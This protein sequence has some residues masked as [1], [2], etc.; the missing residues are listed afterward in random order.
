MPPLHA[1]RGVRRMQ[2]LQFD[3]DERIQTAATEALCNMLYCEPVYS[4]YTD[5]ELRKQDTIKLW[6]LLAGAE[7]IPLAR[8]ASGGLALLTEDGG[9]VDELL[10]LKS[11]GEVLGELAASNSDELRHRGLHTLR[12]VINSSA[13][14]AEKL[15]DSMPLVELLVAVRETSSNP[16]LK[17]IARECLD[18]LVKHGLIKSAQ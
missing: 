3:E 1:L 17:D 7:S 9:V 4:E 8:A 14:R 18:T 16:T 15:L 2:E 6:L 10:A 11:C 13:Q 5:P 12:N